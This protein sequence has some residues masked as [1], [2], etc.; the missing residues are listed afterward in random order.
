VDADAV[1]QDADVYLALFCQV[2]EVLE[3]FSPY[4]FVTHL[5]AKDFLVEQGLELVQDISAED[6]LLAVHAN[7]DQATDV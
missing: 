2:K 5:T 7:V 3:L 1:R 4:R 6:L